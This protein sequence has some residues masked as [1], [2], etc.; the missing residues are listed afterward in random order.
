MSPL[1]L[2]LIDHQGYL[3][4][5]VRFL[6]HSAPKD[7]LNQVGKQSNVKFII[8]TFHSNFLLTKVIW[9]IKKE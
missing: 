5:Y 7:C 1:R 2:E 3:S 8:E 6:A 4:V 9:T